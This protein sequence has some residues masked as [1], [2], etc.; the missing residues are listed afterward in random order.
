VQCP[1]IYDARES[2]EDG[3]AAVYVGRILEGEKLSDR[4]VMLSAKFEFVINLKT[5]GQTAR[6]RSSDASNRE[7]SGAETQNR[8]LQCE[9][10][11]SPIFPI[12]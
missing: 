9:P 12:P 4:P 10:N 2:T 8:C 5:A 3:V 1:A 6:V 11:S 7:V